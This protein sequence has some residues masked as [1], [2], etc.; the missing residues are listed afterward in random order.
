MEP[1]W[2]SKFHVRSVEGCQCVS[3]C[4]R[5]GEEADAIGNGE[6]SDL[7][8]PMADTQRVSEPVVE[9]LQQVQEVTE[10]VDEL[11]PSNSPSLDSPQDRRMHMHVTCMHVVYPSLSTA[12]ILGLRC[13][14]E[15]VSAAS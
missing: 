9:Q 3:W 2:I 13:L 10:P 8:G 1:C 4:F 15:R 11:L 12:F 6:D 7:A 5:H 14:A